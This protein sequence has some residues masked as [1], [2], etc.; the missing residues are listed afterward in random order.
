MHKKKK[1]KKV[2]WLSEEALQMAEEK[3]KR[4]REVKRMGEKEDIPIWI[5]NSKE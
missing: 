5:Q 3:K 1:C 2:K 4:R